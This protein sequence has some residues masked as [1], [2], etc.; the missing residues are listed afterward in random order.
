MTDRLR[1]ITPFLPVNVAQELVKR[2]SPERR[3]VFRSTL[4][5]VVSEP[6]ETVDE[7][8]ELNQ[9]GIAEGLA[10]ALTANIK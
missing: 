7:I 8:H 4:I 9:R 5:E 3:A 2:M 6:A 10:V 1:E